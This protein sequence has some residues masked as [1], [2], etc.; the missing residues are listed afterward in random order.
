M[1]TAYSW[2]ES[3]KAA[4]LETDWAKLRE[5]IKAAEAELHERQRLLSLDHGGTPEERRAIAAALS[6]LKGLRNDVAVW[7]DGQPPDSCE[8]QA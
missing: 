5:R 6:G 7:L 1:T 8:N 2:H 4:V 3:Y